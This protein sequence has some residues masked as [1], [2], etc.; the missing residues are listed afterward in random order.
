MKEKKVVCIIGTTGVG[1]SKLGIE[2]AKHFGGQVISAD[3]MQVYKGLDLLT[4]K[5]TEEE[6]EGVEHHM[7]SLLDPIKDEKFSVT[8]FVKIAEEKLFQISGNDSLPLVV[9]GTMY[10]VESLLWEN[11]ID[12]QLLENKT[13][14][15]FP[16]EIKEMSNKDLHEK[17]REVD[18]VMADKYHFNERRKVM[19]SLEFFYENGSKQSDFY[20]EKD[21]S[22]KYEAIIFWLYCGEEILKK[23]IRERTSG[24]L[25][26]GAL[27]EVRELAE[28]MKE[29]GEQSFDYSKGLLQSIGFK[30][31][32]A[33]LS[34]LGETCKAKR[35]KAVEECAEKLNE[36]T[37]KYAKKQ[38]GWIEN[39]ILTRNVPVFKLCTD[40]LAGWQENVSKV[41]K[42]VTECFLKSKDLPCTELMTSKKTKE[43]AKPQVLECQICSKKFW[44]QVQWESHI[45][46][47]SH[48][49]RKA[50][51]QKI[52]N[53]PNHPLHFQYN[54]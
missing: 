14:R 48:K 10:Y 19:R 16:V 32:E 41:A 35:E 30:E 23:R 31:F 5:V 54:K 40:D 43:Q 44:G 33:Y 25:E 29:K 8:Q 28:T 49:K 53:N 18:Q 50:N 37:L 7:M 22:C 24:M 2:L 17:L 4:N 38:I 15:E 6:M 46:S 51:L 42:K 21:V 13:C 52:K 39:R 45:S 47:K 36:H 1:K 3:S 20:F 12:P 9:G 27:R 34:S 26:K 11:L